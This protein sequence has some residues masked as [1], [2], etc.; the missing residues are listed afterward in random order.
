MESKT[1]Q[2]FAVNINNKCTNN[3]INEEPQEMVTS[4]KITY[5]LCEFSDAPETTAL[6]L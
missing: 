2:H 5:I 4:N 3:S 6:T 1:S